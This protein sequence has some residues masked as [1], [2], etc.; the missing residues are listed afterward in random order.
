MFKLIRKTPKQ[1][2]WAFCILPFIFNYFLW[3]H[4]TETSY[5][6]SAEFED[7][8]WVVLP[9][10]SLVGFTQV[11]SSAYLPSFRRL[12]LSWQLS[13]LLEKCI[14]LVCAVLSTA[15]F[16]FLLTAMLI[17]HAPVHYMEAKVSRLEQTRFLSYHY[18]W[19]L[20]S[21]EPKLTTSNYKIDEK[22]Y[23]WLEENRNERVRIRVRNNLA[24]TS[25]T[26]IRIQ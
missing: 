8:F 9:L 17:R 25:V 18:Y 19:Q 10:M 11:D 2:I 22:T 13:Y 14:H 1:I 16:L 4:G 21:S 26:A 6:M 24:G 20:K 7:A 3:L 5:A 15:S 12:G 23:K